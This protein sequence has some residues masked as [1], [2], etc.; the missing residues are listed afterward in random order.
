[1]FR[2]KMLFFKVMNATLLSLGECCR[3]LKAVGFAGC[4]IFVLVVILVFF[5]E[6][7]QMR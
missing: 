7:I 5:C 1:M 6:V 4:E 2:G 3:D